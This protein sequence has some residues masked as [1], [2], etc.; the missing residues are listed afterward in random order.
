[1]ALVN[2]YLR[3][4]AEPALL[5]GMEVQ[6]RRTPVRASETHG[7]VAA[8]VDTQGHY[9]FSVVQLP[10][11]ALTGRILPLLLLLLG[12]AFY[13]AG[14]LGVARHWWQGGYVSGALVILA[15]TPVVLRLAL[16]YLGLPYAWL[17][18]P[19]FDPRIYAV[20]GWAP[21]LGRL[22]A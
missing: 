11:D 19:L 10:G 6:V 3:E 9:L 4:G 22:V 21:S 12:I 1:M 13:T 2:R 16:L 20:S 5:Q 14:W 18:I 8:L 17:E 15:I 7:L